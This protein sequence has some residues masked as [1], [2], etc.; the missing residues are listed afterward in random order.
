M[1]TKV[2]YIVANGEIAEGYSIIDVFEKLE[3]ARVAVTNYRN[4]NG[5]RA[6]WTL[7]QT[8]HYHDNN[9]VIEYRSGID[10]LYILEYKVN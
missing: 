3:D 8:E 1:S 9:S 10:L 5:G 4:K 6:T 2:V 7:V